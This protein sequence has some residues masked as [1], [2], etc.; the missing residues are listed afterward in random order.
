MAKVFICYF[1]QKN[2]SWHED[3][4]MKY[5]Q[6]V[7]MISL[8][9]LAYYLYRNDSFRIPTDINFFYLGISL[10]F[11]VIGIISFGLSWYS[12]LTLLNRNISPFYSIF[13]HTLSLTGK[14]MPGKI[15]S[16]LGRSMVI[17][18]KY[19]LP[20]SHISY[21]SIYNQLVM[22][23]FGVP[24]SVIAI[25]PFISVSGVLIV[26]LGWFA[27]T[28]F[29]LKHNLF[30]KITLKFTNKIKLKDPDFFSFKKIPRFLYVFFPAYW[31]FMSTSFLFI[32]LSFDNSYLF[33]KMF[34]SPLSG[35]IGNMMVVFPAGLG[36]KEG[37]I[38]TYLGYFST[39]FELAM[40]IAIMHRVVL[41]FT[42]LFLNL[43][44]YSFYIIQR[45]KYESSHLN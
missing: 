17:S 19:N 30:Q 13:S 11:S 37:F 12:T 21:L 34:V 44:A 42:D 45:K 20:I 39:P 4:K 14:Y 33:I 1:S 3:L 32:L 7:I 15:W 22:I 6:Y 25:S 10:F 2:Y 16:L 41:M 23:W 24:F 40:S 35:I 43:T 9:F 26:I 28:V 29:L 38:I 27:I 8:M 5:F 18:E 36:I 31:L